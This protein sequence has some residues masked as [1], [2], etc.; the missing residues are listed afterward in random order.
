MSYGDLSHDIDLSNVQ[1]LFNLNAHHTE[2]YKAKF[3]KASS[4]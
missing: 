2:E 4:T 1:K 3:N